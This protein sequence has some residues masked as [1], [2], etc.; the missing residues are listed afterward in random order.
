LSIDYFNTAL[1]SFELQLGVKNACYQVMYDM[2]APGI[3]GISLPP[4]PTRSGRLQQFDS[5]TLQFILQILKCM[6]EYSNAKTKES[7]FMELIIK[8]NYLE[9]GKR[10]SSKMSTKNPS[11]H[12]L[13]CLDCPICM[14]K[15]PLVCL[16]ILLHK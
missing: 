7:Q 2:L 6:L 4:P 11:G 13:Q 5:M 8:Q 3:V 1:N 14:W 12:S 9:K 16:L 10:T 15:I